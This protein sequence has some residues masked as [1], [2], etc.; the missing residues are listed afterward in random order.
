MKNACSSLDGTIR[1][2]VT[3][4]I[5]AN[6]IRSIYHSLSLYIPLKNSQWV[7]QC[8][9]GLFGDLPREPCSF[10]RV[11]D[12]DDSTPKP[13]LTF[14]SCRDHVVAVLCETLVY[15]RVL[16]GASGLW[17]DSSYDFAAPILTLGKKAWGLLCMLWC[18]K[19]YTNRIVTD[20][21]R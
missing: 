5:W 15:P 20:T 8:Q 6:M 16:F 9:P 21:D 14:E 12:N 17:G 18:T 2:V 3:N 1:Q 10:D 13:Y 19:S 7:I 11:G 4:T